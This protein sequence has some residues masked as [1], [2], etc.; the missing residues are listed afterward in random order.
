MQL[1]LHV[2]FING[3][4]ASVVY[5]DASKTLGLN[6][7]GSWDNAFISFQSALD[8]AV[9]G[10]QIWVAKGTY[11]PSSDYGLGGG[12]RYYHF[13]MING[14]AI[15][16]GF[17]GTENNVSQRNNFGAGEANESI[18]SGDLN[19]DD[20]VTGTGVSLSFSN[21]TENCYHVIYAPNSQGLTNTA[22]LDGFSIQGG[23]GNGIYP[24][25][26]GGGIGIYENSP[27]LA[28]LIISHNFGASGGGITLEGE[29][30]IEGNNHT[31]VT[32]CIIE[33][34][35]AS[36]SGGGLLMA[37]CSYDAEVTNCIIKG[38]M[39][40]CNNC[41]FNSGGGGIYLYHGGKLIN[42]LI[43]DNSAP[44]AAVG[45]GGVYCDWGTFFGG[46]RIFVIN[47]T[48]AHN[49][50]LNW[51]GTNNVI[52][53][54]EFQN[55][56]LWGNTSIN[57]DLSNFNGS[58]Y[59][60]CC[61]FPMLPGS[62]NIITNPNFINPML[63]DYRI[64]SNSS[65][66]NSGNNSFNTEAY[67]IRGAQRIQNTTVDIGAYEYTGGIDISTV[68]V[69][70]TAQASSFSTSTLSDHTMNIGWTRG[71]GDKV[72]VIA[73]RGTPVNSYPDNGILYNA[74]AEFGS[75]TQIGNKN[76][77]VYNGTGTSVNVS[78]LILGTDY[79]FAIYEYKTVA[80]CY[81]TPAL[82]GN[83]TTT[84]Y[85]TPVTSAGPCIM[86]IS[87]ITT[88]G[89]TGE[90]NF[91]SDCTDTSYTDYSSNNI[92]TN[93]QLG[94]TTLTFTSANNPM[95]FSVWIDFNN[96]GIFENSERV[97]ANANLGAVLTCT[98]SFI[99]PI[100]A[101]PG[102]HRMRVRGEYWYY[103]T[104]NDPCNQLSYGETEDYS[105]NVTAAPPCSGTPNPGITLST[106]SSACPDVSFTLSIQHPIIASGI[107][108]QWQLSPDNAIWTDIS[109]ATNQT[110]TT[111]QNVSSYYRCLASC[112]N[113]SNT[114]NSTPV[115][116]IMNPF[117]SC[118][119]TPMTSINPC[120]IWISKVTTSG[121]LSDFI[122]KT[123]CSDTS[124]TD[125]SSTIIASNT[126]GATTTMSFTSAPYNSSN[127]AMAFSVWV[128]F[129]DNGLFD[130]WERVITNGNSIADSTIT[131]S[132]VVPL[133]A[134]SGTH[135]MRVRAE[136]TWYGAPYTPC[137]QLNYGET[138]DYAFTVIGPCTGVPEPGNTLSSSNS[139]C[140]NANFTLS[141]QHNV[142]TSGISYQ[143]QSSPDNFFWT[144][145]TGATNTTLTTSQ[146]AL[147]YYRCYVYC[148]NEY[149]GNY[150]NII[151]VKINPSA[152]CNCIPIASVYPC[153]K[154]ITSV[155]SSGGVTD[156]DNSSSCPSSS[157]SDY[158][159]TNI[160][161]NYQLSTTTMSF[162][163]FIYSMAYS[164]WID[165]N[166]N[167]LFEPAE[168]VIANNNND[169]AIPCIDSISIPISAPPGTHKMRVRGDAQWQGAPTYPCNQLYEG[170]TEDY[171]FTVLAIPCSGI[172]DP[173]NTISTLNS[174]CQDANFTL[175]LQNSNFSSGI[176]YQWQLST[177]NTHWSHITG[178][179]NA[180]LI[181]MQSTST[182]YRCIVSCSS[183][184]SVGISNPINISM[185]GPT[186]CYCIPEVSGMACIAMWISNVTTS[187][188]V[189]DFNNSTDCAAS[190][191]TDYSGTQ[192]AS[193]LQLSTTT[194]SFTT[195]GQY[196]MAYS[197][198][199]DYNDNGVFEASEHVINNPNSWDVL[200]ITD[201]F[202]VPL[203]AS[204]GAHRMRVR[205]NFYAL[206]APTE[207][208]N[209]LSYGETEDYSFTVLPNCVNPTNGGTIAADQFLCNGSIP[210][211]IT[212]VT[213][214]S[215]Q[216]GLLEYQ[217]QQSTTNSNA[218]FANISG[219]TSGTYTP[220][221]VSSKTWY[222]RLA[223]V[224]CI[225]DWTGA[226]A[227][228]VI[229]ITVD[230][231]ASLSIT[232]S[233]N[234]VCQNTLV[235][236]TPNP[237]YGGN[238]P[239]YQWYV[240]DILIPSS[241]SLSNGL[242]ASYPFDG[243]ANN[244]SGNGY[245]GIVNGATLTTDRFGIP[246]S[247]YSFD[248][249]G[250]N[251]VTNNNSL[252]LTDISLSL[253]INGNTG[254]PFGYEDASNGCCGFGLYY[255]SPN[256][257]ELI[258]RGA[259]NYDMSWGNINI[260]GWN[261]YVITISSTT[262]TTLYMNSQQV[263]NNPSATSY[264]SSGVPLTFGSAGANGGY[265]QG[266]IDD[267]YLYNRC[268]SSSEVLELYNST[269]GSKF[270]YA[271]SNNDHIKC[272]MTSSLNCAIN[273]PA[274]S[275]TIEAN[276]IT[277]SAPT[278]DTI[279]TFNSSATIG[280]LVVSGSEVKWY[281]AAIGGNVFSSSEALNI[282]STYYASQTLSGCESHC[283]LGVKVANGNVKTV[284]LH[285]F[286]E[287]LFDFSIGNNMVEAQDID[288]N[289]GL[290]FPKYG[291]GIAD[292]IQ[293]DL[294]QE[295]SPFNSI[296][297]SVSGINLLT[298]GLASFQV[299]PSLSG[300][301]YIKVRTRN[302]LEIW[303]AI[304]VPFNT[305]TINYDFTTLAA[306]AYQAPGGN[307]PQIQIATGVFAFFLGDLDQSF[308]V[309]FDDFNLFEPYLNGGT[310][311]FT[312]ADFNGN[313]LVD[314]DDFNLFEP[315]LTEG[316]FSQYPGMKK[317]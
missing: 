138:E 117:S 151:D 40:S 295:N 65:C 17:A 59:T 240:N 154:W 262:G 205:G 4:Y 168:Q 200:T 182:F 106:A 165:F 21:N 199:I 281:N 284:N 257:P 79:Y 36:H 175:S 44:Y 299:S 99:V 52:N 285:L 204:P 245:N 62:G 188:G 161:S 187:G 2:F 314:F 48:I 243:N 198:W 252:A 128:D 127:D 275:N 178:A 12:S 50:A 64:A 147:T 269:G 201:N 13:R 119:C 32:N 113:G 66:I 139:I 305:A 224:N 226:A 225:P 28:N 69:S 92:A 87:N 209:Q 91:S 78:G 137:N 118:Y 184:E 239:T 76:Y 190:S 171:A 53:G 15:Y 217:W 214:P 72:L 27:T 312:I 155:T 57:G 30:L 60:N 235:A 249:I 218:G 311:G 160:A 232:S 288:W 6:N 255:I 67:D 41:T 153:N 11:K 86:W 8:V 170:E 9:S 31:K 208:C 156:F 238:N 278:G 90:I 258:M 73:R 216:T 250:N 148:S 77:V 68:C 157:Y 112:S 146:T 145:I 89:G 186:A 172:P 167:G 210:A 142:N 114:G 100:T 222:K 25:A 286:L 7:G 131:D 272:V 315:R 279:Q 280:D 290:T 122:N 162:G 202:T 298:N 149:T 179:N 174:V 18:L 241:S 152:D 192:T 121:G 129:N 101:M 70:P 307:D 189:T 196:P 302:H 103:G 38:N 71:S 24:F 287:G 223:K 212:N 293:V 173:G 254:R 84:G 246:N 267:I 141:L 33:Y 277:P 97:I 34:N 80:N 108:Y 166:D 181:M 236:F 185:N 292:K 150:S 177:D 120:S 58:S 47:C 124:Y 135:K 19:G 274:T 125:Y 42:C 55:C 271:P 83:A 207:P 268:L 260:N 266:K 102:T 158:S 195:S 300:N 105:F 309:D 61:S 20:L 180:T 316:P 22:I 54:G 265:F 304:A 10:D 163:S 237:I 253:W 220:A 213:L 233:A 85:C 231:V 215:G 270:I 294:Y 261:H 123:D 143:W 136:K 247:A 264:S 229:S 109:G 283:R 133:Y 37:N 289:T 276:I 5:V 221:V 203:T 104:P 3:L 94:T 132:F 301:Y 88:S 282:D 116:I 115:Y 75:G 93:S 46:Q 303:S 251:I 35:L 1:I 26:E 96:N 49:T 51:G 164:V 159:A 256:E 193:N 191:Y 291:A 110:L 16:G 63:S 242:I 219:A 74:N 107:T 130:D 230:P 297:V 206:G 140:P 183:G 313:G 45:G 95:A 296:G 126:G 98:D 306:N 111:T 263:N 134:P 234:N 259:N 310:Y 81:L 228:N 56:I 308:S 176:T 197:V 29:Q 82:T 194:M 39:M 14:V 273:N 23:N 211:E 43:T 227:S 244:E 248:G 169:G 144:E 317:K